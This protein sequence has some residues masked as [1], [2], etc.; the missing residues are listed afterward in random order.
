MAGQMLLLAGA[1]LLVLAPHVQPRAQAETPIPRLQIFTALNQHDADPLVLE[2]L[3]RQDWVTG[4]VVRPSASSNSIRNLREQG[5]QV[6]LGMHGHPE[7]LS[8]RAAHRGMQPP[9]P[10]AELQRI[11]EVAGPE[12]M[13][14][15]LFEDDS[16][17]VGFPQD[18]LRK[19][20]GSHREAWNLFNSYLETALKPAQQFHGELWGICGYAASAHPFAAHGIHRVLVERANDDVEDLPTAV[21]FA[22]GAAHQYGRTWGLDLSLWW[23]PIYGCTHDLPASLFRRYLYLSFFGGARTFL[24]EGGDLTARPA[25]QAEA[26]IIS[27]V[28]RFHRTVKDLDPGEPDAVVAI[29][30]PRDHGWITPPYWR[31][32]NGAW[33]YAR[34]PYRPG[35]RGIDGLFGTAFPGCVFVMDPFPFGAYAVDEPPASPFSL[36]CVTPTFAPTPA[37]QYRAQPQLPFG[38]FEN[39]DEARQAILAGRKDPSPYRPMADTRWGQIFD[40]LNDETDSSVLSKYPV[41]ILLG[42]IHVDS[43][44]AQRLENYVR[45]GGA[46]IAAAGVF[47]PDQRN[48][49]GVA[50]F[51]EQHVGRAWQWLD[52]PLV[53]EAYRY[54]PCDAKTL[55]RVEV[56]ARTQTGAPLV[57]RHNLGKGAVH[58]VLAPWYEAGHTAFHG[59][60]RCL[61]DSIIEQVQP[62]LVEGLPCDWVCTTGDRERWVVLANHDGQTWQGK[63]AVRH[64]EVVWNTSRELLTGTDVV[65]A[66]GESAV[67]FTLQIP[68][69]DVRI[70]HLAAQNVGGGE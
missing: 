5:W 33:N 20:P 51:A 13:W 68:P 66:S 7:T 42:P 9:D 65:S 4:V 29:M 59:V 27:E 8:R 11:A 58:T 14:R 55:D 61:L 70:I 24:I 21:A 43:E 37:D 19:K 28:A 39:R 41:L 3:S 31:T 48:L 17:G 34:V 36:S 12:L 26:P 35:D 63:V 16:A 64:G 32:S 22:R 46:L 38:R 2:W 50:L 49:A 57:V 30:L 40:V 54:L 18:L 53:H 69:Y 10:A 6:V 1:L 25:V 44:L 67:E 56:L 62:V 15:I 52:G 45:A 47:G 60:A 23:G